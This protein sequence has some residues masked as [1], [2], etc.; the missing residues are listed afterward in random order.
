[1]LLYKVSIILTD[2]LHFSI[3]VKLFFPILLTQQIIKR[4]GWSPE[5]ILNDLLRQQ[6]ENAYLMMKN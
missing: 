2:G 6:S 4:G 3:N 5:R 1:M